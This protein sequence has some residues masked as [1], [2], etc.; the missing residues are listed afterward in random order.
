MTD[1]LVFLL[2]LAVTAALLFVAVYFVIMLSDLECDYLNSKTCCQK[3]NRFVLPE[4][5]SHCSISLALIFSWHYVLFIC[6]AAPFS[7]YL[8]HRYVRL[9]PDS[10]GMYDPTEIRNRGKL[11]H[12]TKE[13]FIKLGYHLVM[14][15]IYLYFLLYTL[16]TGS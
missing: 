2:S 11:Q 9:P 12:A 14:F 8:I 6:F 16:I 13:T 3:L 10:M 5:I 7:V 1:L 15:F 4:I